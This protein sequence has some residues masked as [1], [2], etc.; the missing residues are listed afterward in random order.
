MSPQQSGAN[1]RGDPGG[2]G[3]SASISAL[4]NVSAADSPQ[5]M[6]WQAKELIGPYQL[7]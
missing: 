2:E 7:L 4:S 3:P 5:V 6:V 1:D